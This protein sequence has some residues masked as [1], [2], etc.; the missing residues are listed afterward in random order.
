MG[1]NDLQVS[2]SC[3]C[4]RS[5][6]ARAKDAGGTISCT[7]GKQVAV[8][9]LSDLR[10][11][12]GADAYITNP[13]EA[14]RKLQ[15]QGISPTGDRCL[16]CGATSPAL[17]SCHA[18]CESSH[19]KQPSSD[20]GYSVPKLLGLFILPKLLFFLYLLFRKEEAAEGPER[21]GHDV[22][23]G[24]TLPVCGPCAAT[25]GNVTRPKVARQLMAK[26]PALSELLEYYPQLELTVERPNS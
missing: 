7:C 15:A 5:V 13:A 1:T 20:G 21:R 9:R 17:Y 22:A 11:L 3:G 2:L 14:I 19:V 24:F 16:L 10:T 6:V 26:S 8:P 18:V 12:A 4:G 23:V 25:T